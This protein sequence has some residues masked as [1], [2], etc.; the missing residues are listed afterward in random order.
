MICSLSQAGGLDSVFG[1][2]DY[3]G[4]RA[5]AIALHLTYKSIRE[6]IRSHEG[7]NLFCLPSALLG[8]ET[9]RTVFVSSELHEIV[10][11]PPWPTTWE[12]RRHANLRALLDGFTEGDWIT[13]AEDPFDK[14]LC[15]ILARVAPVEDEV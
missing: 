12:G 4:D 10:N 7:R 1:K 2:N 5:L 13:V 3:V 14:N 8:E 9:P 11:G 15:A 6:A